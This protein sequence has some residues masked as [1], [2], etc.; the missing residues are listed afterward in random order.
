MQEKF[1]WGVQVHTASV[2][3]IPLKAAVFCPFF[4]ENQQKISSKSA[5]FEHFHGCAGML[6]V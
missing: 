1:I 6:E 4:A 2:Q 5:K 3:T